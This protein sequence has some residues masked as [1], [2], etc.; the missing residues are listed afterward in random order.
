MPSGFSDAFHAHRISSA[1]P[2]LCGVSKYRAGPSPSN[3]QYRA[4]VPDT[5]SH[6]LGDIR[7]L[8]LEQQ[9]DEVADIYG[10]KTRPSADGLFNP[11]EIGDCTGHA[12]TNAV[13]LAT[14]ATRREDAELSCRD[15]FAVSPHAIECID[16]VPWA[17]A[18]EPHVG[19]WKT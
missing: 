3:I 4:A 13:R 6:G 17:E 1:V 15:V 14:P 19:F 12:E 7:K 9:V 18:S 16:P 2:S 5:R 10:L 11:S 8:L